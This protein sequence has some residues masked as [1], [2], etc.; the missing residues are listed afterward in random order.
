[1]LEDLTGRLRW[2]LGSNNSEGLPSTSRHLW[3][4]WIFLRG[5]GFI[6]FSAFYSFYFQIKALVGPDGILPARDY[7]QAVEA[8]LHSARWWY[9]PTV[10]WLSTSDHALM[11]VCCIGLIASLLVLLN[12]WPRAN[13]FIC[14]VCF[15]SFIAVA[16]D[17]ASYQS[18]GM[19]L[20]AGFISLFFAPSGV[21]PGLGFAQ[22]PS[23]ASLFLL[24]WEWFRIYFQSGVVKLASGDLSWRNLTAMDD[25][26]QNGPL[27][28]WL[29]WYVQHLPHGFHAS[30]TVLVLAVE[31]ALVWMLF[32]PRRFRIICFCIVTPMQLSIILTANY[33]FLNYIVLCLGFLLLDDRVFE[34]WL[35]SRLRSWATPISP[36]ILATRVGAI[37]WGPKALQGFSVAGMVISGFFLSWLFYASSVQIFWMF[38]P[39]VHFPSEP[40]RYLEPFRVADSYGLFAVMTHQRYEIEFQGSNDGGKT[41]IPFP[42]R[43]KPQDPAKAPGIYAPYQPRFEWN[44]WF[45]SLGSWRQYRFVVWTEERL[46]T[47]DPDV[48]E[49]FAHDPFGGNPPDRVRAVAYQYWFTD[50]KTKHVTGM[51]WRREFLGDYAPELEREPDGKIVIVESPEGSDDQ[52]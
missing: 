25:Y 38:F 13:L 30:V 46:L 6:Y 49:L 3:A 48:L 9:A 35:P 19:L 52:P 12:L 15:L 21:R 14:F 22:G 27:P 34:P 5:L 29:G 43:Y 7:L 41:W 39:S 37:S 51:W 18:D 32:L 28:S 1:M 8:G 24:Q 20:E 2:L 45:A 16:Q 42:F 11:T 50:W 44:L 23:R 47:K 31:L 33:A 40:I 17:F 4:R 26:Y 36:S 10:F